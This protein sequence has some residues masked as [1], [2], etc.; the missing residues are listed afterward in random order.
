MHLAVLLSLLVFVTLAV[1]WYSYGVK[2]A[3]AKVPVR[4]ETV[5][6]RRR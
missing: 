3:E 4:I 2:R 5:H 1:A 6:R